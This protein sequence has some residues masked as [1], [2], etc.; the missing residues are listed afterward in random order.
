MERRVCRFEIPK[1]PLRAEAYAEL[2]PAMIRW[3]TTEWRTS[4]LSPVSFLLHRKIAPNTSTLLRNVPDSLYAP[5][6]VLLSDRDPHTS[7]NGVLATQ[8]YVVQM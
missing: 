6:P 8:I 5:S 7:T 3:M 2:E 4:D 1:H